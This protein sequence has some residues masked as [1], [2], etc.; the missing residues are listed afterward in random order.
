[1][2]AV[3]CRDARVSVADAAREARVVSAVMFLAMAASVNVA[4]SVDET[5]C[6]IR[7]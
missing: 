7:E 1:M 6:D 2:A 3:L 5:L 4:A